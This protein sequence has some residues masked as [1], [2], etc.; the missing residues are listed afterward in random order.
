MTKLKETK[1]LIK[2]IFIYLEEREIHNDE[3]GRQICIIRCQDDLVEKTHSIV[4]EATK[5]TNVRPCEVKD[6]AVYNSLFS[7]LRNGEPQLIK[8]ISFT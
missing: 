7:I 8:S 4:P 3:F 1:L 6:S 2:P 5:E